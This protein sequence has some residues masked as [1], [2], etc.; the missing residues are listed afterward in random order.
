MHMRQDDSAMN[1]NR[2]YRPT[3]L[4]IG[5]RLQWHW[6]R[7]IR[8]SEP[9]RAFCSH[10]HGM[11]ILSQEYLARFNYHAIAFYLHTRMTRPPN[12]LL[13]RKY[14]R[15]SHTVRHGTAKKS[16]HV[17]VFLHNGTLTQRTWLFSYV[18][19]STML[20]TDLLAQTL[21]I[22]QRIWM[23][24]SH[25]GRKTCKQYLNDFG[26]NPLCTGWQNLASSCV[27]RSSLNVC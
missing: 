26:S 2:R 18:Y 4:S 27:A 1:F 7:H 6:H 13:Y 12:S 22:Q 14:I 25:E 3:V 15:S 20:L 9:K 23:N 8:P 24:A 16:R 10:Q 21:N 19:K 17:C 5:S 11:G